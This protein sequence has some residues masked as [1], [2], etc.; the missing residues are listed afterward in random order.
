MNKNTKYLIVAISLFCLTLANAQPPEVSGYK[1]NWYDEFFGSSLD[2]SKWTAVFSTNPTNNSLHAYLPANVLVNGGDLVLVS[3][4]EPFGQFDYRSGQVISTSAQRYGRFEVRGRLPTSRGMWPAIWLLPNAAWPSQGEIDIMENRGDQPFLTSS[5]F[6]W[7]TNPPFNHF[8]VYSEQ[9]TFVDGDVNNYHNSLHTYAVEWDPDQIRFYVDGVHHYTVRD[10]DVGGF[11]SGTQSAPMNLIINTAIGGNFLADPDQTTQWPQF[12]RVDYVYVYDRIGEAVLEIENGGFD[13]GDASLSA[14]K[15]FGNTVG[16]VRAVT[17]PTQSGS[18]ALKLYGQFQSGTN[19]SGVEQGATVQAGD[20]IQV[21][22]RT[23]IDPNDSIAG[24]ANEVLLKLDYYNKNY[25]EFGSSEYISSESI[26]VANGSSPNGQWIA[27]TLTGTVP[28]E[29]VEARVAIVFTQQ[30]SNPGSVFVDSIEFNNLSQNESVVAH[31]AIV[32]S[33]QLAAG[34][35]MSTHSSNDQYFEVLAT[36]GSGRSPIEVVFETST[37]I[38]RPG[39]IMLAAESSANSSNL[40]QT[41]EAFDYDAQ[42]FVVA[43]VRL[44]DLTDSSLDIELSGDVSRFVRAAD[45]QMRIKLRYDATGPTLM[46]PWR[47]KIDTIKWVVGP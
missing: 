16:N 20:Q 18:G 17:S 19:Y 30:N 11:L 1:I 4:D 26:V 37:S 39:S 8:F 40:A 27:H 23:F 42:Q 14:W 25:G 13:L 43:D 47:S 6:H 41:I 46:F 24:T 33:G 15:W 34:N 5:A 7:G 29:A 12:F 9:E 28:S 38:L 31:S 35:V 2:E 22:C 3:T 44:I 10:D 45:G 36:P 21:N 32:E